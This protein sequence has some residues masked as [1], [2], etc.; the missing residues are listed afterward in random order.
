[1]YFVKWLDTFLETNNFYLKDNNCMI[2]LILFNQSW[3]Q[4]IL[5]N[6]QEILI[7]AQTDSILSTLFLIFARIS[8]LLKI[9]LA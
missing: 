3:Y 5:P 9:I 1:M 6:E 2:L 4:I 8:L 7:Q